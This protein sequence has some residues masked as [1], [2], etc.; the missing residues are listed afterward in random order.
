MPD[1]QCPV[2]ASHQTERVQMRDGTDSELVNC[3]SCGEFVVTMECA[4]DLP[5]IIRGKPDAPMR[6]SHAVRNMQRRYVRPILTS[7]LAEKFIALPL[8]RPRE[9][10][11]NLIR[12]FGENLRHLGQELDLHPSR[13]KSIVGT[14]S[15]EGFGL[16]VRHLIESHMLVGYMAEALGEIG[17]ANATL[18]FEGWDYFESLVRG[19]GIYGQAFMAMKYGVEPLNT[20]VSDCFAPQVALAGFKLIRLDEEPRAGLIDNRMRVEIQNSDFLVADLTHGNAGAYWE[21]GYAEGL[22]KPVFYTCERSVFEQSRTHFDT[23]HHYTVIW[24][25]ENP[26]VGGIELKMAIRATL[27]HLAKMD[28]G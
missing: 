27:P 2:C 28:D 26:D 15:D 20:I 19:K 11:D 5:A 10:A 16:I 6:I 12:W 24:N 17:V 3:Q 4:A 9:Q 1:G 13:M 21:A 7:I 22:G 25:N 23:N 14:Q 18:S 8:P